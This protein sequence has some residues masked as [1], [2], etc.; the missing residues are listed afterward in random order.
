MKEQGHKRQLMKTTQNSLDTYYT[1]DSF[2]S[3]RLCKD[4][5]SVRQVGRIENVNKQ[6]GE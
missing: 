2:Q 3:R 6:T 5:K 4:F 1:L